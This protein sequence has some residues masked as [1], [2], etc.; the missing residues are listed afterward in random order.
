MLYMGIFPGRLK[1]AE[2]KPFFKE[3]RKRDPLNY[4][5]ISLL[6]SFSKIFEKIIL[7]W[8]YQHVNEYQILAGEQ[9]GFRWQ[10]STN[11]ASYVL[12]N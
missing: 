2:I 11:K 1:Y 7:S 9:F 4:R 6:T 5:P 12:L 10:S 3:G 8:L